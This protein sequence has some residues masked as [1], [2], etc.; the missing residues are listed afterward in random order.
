M[1]GTRNGK[2][3]EYHYDD[4]LKFEGEYKNDVKLNGKGFDS[5]NNIVYELKHGKGFIK[6]YDN[7][8]SELKFEGE[9]LNG[10]RHGKGK[11]YDRNGKLEFEGEYLN[12]ERNGKGKEYDENGKLKFEGEY[13]NGEI[14]NGYGFGGEYYKGKRWNGFRESYKYTKFDMYDEIEVNGYTYYS[15]GELKKD[16]SYR[17]I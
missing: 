15:N 16:E 4:T 6:E 13:L 9:Y 2:G 3:K 1:N 12:G 14:W 8:C 10:K 17:I 5:N 7:Y 11:E